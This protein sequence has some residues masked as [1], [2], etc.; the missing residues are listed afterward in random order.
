M[1]AFAES[2]SFKTVVGRIIVDTKITDPERIALVTRVATDYAA[3]SARALAGEEIAKELAIADATTKNLERELKQA[4]GNN[5]SMWI[6][7]TL[8]GVL[9]NLVS[10]KE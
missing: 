2:N 8:Q 1:T 5:L 7:S 4:I 10:A 6:S 3:L 9:V